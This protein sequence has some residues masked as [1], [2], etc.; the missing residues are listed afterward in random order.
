MLYSPSTNGFYTPAIHG[1]AIPSDA[2]EVSDELHASLIN[3]SAQGK[4]I[5]PDAYGQPVLTDPA[6]PTA[7][8]I[9]IRIQAERDRRQVIGYEVGGKWFHGDLSSRIQQ[10]G[11]VMLGVNVPAGLQWK[12]MDGS[13]VA[14]TAEL[15]ASVF[16]AA[17]A[18]DI[19]I[20]AAAETH[21]AAM[22]A[23]NDPAAYDFSAGWPP[24]FEG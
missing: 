23:S 13:F 21:R 18:S 11:L 15:A 24:V 8:E 10:L 1:A 14:M 22:E 17:A 2:V 16:A 6:P 3:G 20:F 7:A 5:K 4:G 19:A 9:W 12:T